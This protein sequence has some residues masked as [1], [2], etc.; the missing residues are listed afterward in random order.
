MDFVG[1]LGQQGVDVF[2][3][4][5]TPSFHRVR[6]GADQTARHISVEGGERNAQFLGRLFSCKITFHDILIC[7]SRLTT[8]LVLIN[9]M[10]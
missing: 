1:F 7:Q 9:M 10:A 4:V 2:G 5:S 3:A 6:F 8:F